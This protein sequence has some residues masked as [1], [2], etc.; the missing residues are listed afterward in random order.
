WSQRSGPRLRLRAT[1]EPA[2]NEVEVELPASAGSFQPGQQV[3]LA[4]RQYGI[5]PAQAGA[6]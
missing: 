2:G 5:F 6:G 3:R 4:A 1:L